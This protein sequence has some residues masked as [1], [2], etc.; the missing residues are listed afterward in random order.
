MMT[1]AELT[2]DLRLEDAIASLL[3]VRLPM[4]VVELDFSNGTWRGLPIHPK[5]VRQLMDIANTLSDNEITFLKLCALLVNY[6]RNYEIRRLLQNFGNPS[7][8]IAVVNTDAPHGEAVISVVERS[9]ETVADV[10]IG[11]NNNR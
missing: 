8:P 1:L 2:K 4:V 6:G 9:D 3:E 7:D 10:N 5:E 11:D